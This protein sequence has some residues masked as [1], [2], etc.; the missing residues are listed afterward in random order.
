M[1]A[2]FHWCFLQLFDQLCRN[3]K[4]CHSQFEVC[5]RANELSKRRVIFW[6]RAENSEGLTPSIQSKNLKRSATWHSHWIVRELR[7]K[8]DVR[9]F[10]LLFGYAT[11]V[12]EYECYYNGEHFTHS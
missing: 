2:G 6:Q 11:N 3:K 10:N 8:S 1:G 5:C 7:A 4:T 12:N 9:F